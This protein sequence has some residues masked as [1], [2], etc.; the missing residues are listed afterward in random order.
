MTQ[1]QRRKSYVHDSDLSFKVAS[2]ISQVHDREVTS[3]ANVEGQVFDDSENIESGEDS[4]NVE[5][6]I[7]SDID[8]IEFENQDA[9]DS[10]HSLKVV[11]NILQVLQNREFIGFENIEIQDLKASKK[12]GSGE[13]CQNKK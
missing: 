6:E 4:S 9:Q 8:D 11:S 1:L 10:N 13:S 5:E 12:V 7:L 2:Y 3:F